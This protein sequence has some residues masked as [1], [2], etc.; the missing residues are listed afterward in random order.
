MGLNERIPKLK[1][2]QLSHWRRI[3]LT[4]VILLPMGACDKPADK[5]PE[6]QSAQAEEDRRLVGG[7]Q[8]ERAH[9]LGRVAAVPN[10]SPEEVAAILGTPTSREETQVSGKSVPRHTYLQGM[11]EVVFVDG[12]AEWITVF[13]A[14]EISLWYSPR[15]LRALGFPDWRP[16]FHNQHVIRW[17]HASGI[18]QVSVFPGQQGLVDY[19]YICVNRIP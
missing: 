12:K 10:R 1:L 8:S 6:V 7:E 5:A 2:G 19:F 11:V 14:Q 4:A 3:A 17:E 13:P 18:R 9:D 15:A 16:T